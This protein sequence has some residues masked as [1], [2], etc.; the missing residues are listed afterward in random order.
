M[1]EAEGVPRVQGD[2]DALDPPV[3]TD[4]L[5]ALGQLLATAEPPLVPLPVPTPPPAA[6]VG[7]M[8]EDGFGP[9][10]ELLVDG[11]AEAPPRPTTVGT[12]GE[13]LPV[14]P[15]AAGPTGR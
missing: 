4:A 3:P 5:D 6:F 13:G 12:C 7:T 9:A 14:G 1:A 10:G 2:A 15:G 11:A 8:D